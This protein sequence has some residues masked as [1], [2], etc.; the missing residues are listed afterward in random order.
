MT[1]TEQDQTSISVPVVHPLQ[2]L[3]ADEIRSAR[4]LLVEHGL[5]T[6]PIRFAYLGLE[7]PPKADVLAGRPIDRRVRATLLDINTGE[8]TIV[9]AS[10]TRRAIDQQTTTKP[11]LDGQPPILLEEFI[12][13]RRDRQG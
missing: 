3:S 11:E 5:V 4:Q 2:G 8:C 7:E 1:I 10:L 13:R 6:D 12:A 9:I